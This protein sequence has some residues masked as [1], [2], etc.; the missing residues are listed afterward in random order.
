MAKSVTGRPREKKSS[1]RGQ[2]ISDPT[3]RS[4]LARIAWF[5]H[6]TITLYRVSPLGIGS[7]WDKT[8]KQLSLTLLPLPP[9]HGVASSHRLT[10]GQYGSIGVEEFAKGAFSSLRVNITVPVFV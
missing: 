3:L 1:R 6:A 2:L 8:E 5:G 7:A 9:R 4:E 10:L